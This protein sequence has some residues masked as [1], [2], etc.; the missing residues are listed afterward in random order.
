MIKTSSYTAYYFCKVAGLAF[1]TLAVL[2]V[3]AVLFPQHS[4]V[5]G[6][7]SIKSASDLFYTLTLSGVALGLGYFTFFRFCVIE[8]DNKNVRIIRGAKRE[9][10]TWSNVLNVTKVIGCTPPV[11]RMTFKDHRKPAYFIMSMAAFVSIGVWSWDFTGFYEYAR[12]K[13]DEA[14]DA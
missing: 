3:H 14:N 4:V 10:T 8:Y 5:D 9:R 13:I 1:G 11:Y 6:I 7:E 2:L 12:E